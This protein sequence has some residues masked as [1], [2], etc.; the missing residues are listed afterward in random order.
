MKKILG[1][2]LTLILSGTLQSQTLE[3][4]YAEIQQEFNIQTSYYWVAFTDKVGSP[5]S[6]EHPEAFL[7]ERAIEKRKRFNIKITIEDLPVNR[8][9]EKELLE[10]DPKSYIHSRSKWLNGVTL[11]S[12]DS[13]RT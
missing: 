9:Y 3:E 10:V 11:V 7:S 5:Y 4:N 8:R 6:V 2:I 13:D 12:T 1:F